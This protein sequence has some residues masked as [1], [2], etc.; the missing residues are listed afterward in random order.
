MLHYPWGRDGQ[1]WWIVRQDAAKLVG[2][3]GLYCGTC[4]IYIAY[5]EN[6]VDELEK[7]SQILG[8]PIRE[9]RCDGCLSDMVMPQRVDCPHGFRRCARDKKVMWCFQCPDF[10]CQRLKDFTNI[11]IINGISHHAHVIDDLYYMKEHG[12]EQWVEKQ[13]IAGCCPQC[14]KRLYWFSRV[15]PAC[16]TPIRQNPAQL[17]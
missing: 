14:G 12:V 3:C 15:C 16:H 9:I 4:P 17:S 2:I 10:P 5:Q 8:I 13:Q 1:G 7:T 11:H 6:D